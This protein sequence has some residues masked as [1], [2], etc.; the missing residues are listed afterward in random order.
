M[1]FG[2][3][4]EVGASLE[5]FE[6]GVSLATGVTS[7]DFVG[8]GVTGG[9]VGT[10]VTETITGSTINEV[11][12]EVPAGDINGVNTDFVIANTPTSG[13]LQVYLNGTRQKV[14]DDFTL[15]TATIT[16]LIAPPS[17]SNILVDYQY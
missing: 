11:R 9:A 2:N 8:S 4:Q 16:F 10:A 14:T 1:S 12:N 17:G 6:E 3:P 13:T 5:I 7:I 15:S